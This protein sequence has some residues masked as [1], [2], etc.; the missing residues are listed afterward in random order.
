M[1]PILSYQNIATLTPVYMT[2]MVYVHSPI[3]QCGG[4]YFIN[5]YYFYFVIFLLLLLL[6]LNMYVFTFVIC[7]IMVMDRVSA[8]KVY[9]YYY[10]KCDIGKRLSA[11]HG[12][13]LFFSTY[14][15][16]LIV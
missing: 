11:T 16:F 5:L 10:E 15:V 4:Q 6:Y 7:I 9:Y 12:Y 2:P 1:C 13:Y 8:I 3:R 14:Q